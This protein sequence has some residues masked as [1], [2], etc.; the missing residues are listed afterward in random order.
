MLNF[1]SCFIYFLSVSSYGPGINRDGLF[2]LEIT[3]VF[4]LADDTLNMTAWIWPGSFRLII[5]FQDI[6]W[7]IL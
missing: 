1:K 4:V 2:P 3:V 7:S 6:F 5:I